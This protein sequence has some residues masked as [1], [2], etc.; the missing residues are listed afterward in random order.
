[1]SKLR[2]TLKLISITPF[3]TTCNLLQKLQGFSK[4]APFAYVHCNSRYCSAQRN[5]R[6]QDGPGLRDFIFQTQ[7]VEPKHG[8]DKKEIVSYGME[9]CV[10]YVRKEDV[11]GKNC[12][13]N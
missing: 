3:N 1:M 12:K 2:Y 11:N 6:T 13:G 8:T 9:E 5:A 10:P 7:E 4:I